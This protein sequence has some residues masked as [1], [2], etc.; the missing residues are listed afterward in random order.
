MTRLLAV[1][2]QSGSVSSKY[3]VSCQPDHPS[4]T[5]DVLLL[6][7]TQSLWDYKTKSLER[8]PTPGHFMC[9]SSQPLPC[10]VSEHFRETAS[11]W[12]GITRQNVRASSGRFHQGVSPWGLLET[13]TLT[14]SLVGLS[15]PFTRHKAGAGEKVQTMPSFF[16]KFGC[17]SFSLVSLADLNFQILSVSKDSMSS[18][19]PLVVICSVCILNPREADL[20]LLFLLCHLREKSHLS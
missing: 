11:A 5:L 7:P 14:A 9:Q 18:F 4:L 3:R 13:P 19:L 17:F 1:G 12:A 20:L 6:T 8:K 10:V 16:L 15:T 2:V